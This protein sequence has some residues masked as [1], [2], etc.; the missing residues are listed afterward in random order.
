MLIE[1]EPPL[2][3]QNLGLGGIDITRLIVSS[4]LSGQTLYP[5]SEW[6]LSVY[7]ARVTD[8]TVLK[9]RT[10]TREHV[11]LIAWGMLFR[12]REGALEQARRFQ[13]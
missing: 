6:P 13:R 9:S 4:R 3:G 7:V 8:D 2:E 11:K 1:I 12:T 5:V 10:F